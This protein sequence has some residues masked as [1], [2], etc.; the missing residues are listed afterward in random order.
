M[1]ARGGRGGGGGDLEYGAIVVKCIH[2]Y[3]YNDTSTDTQIRR[4]YKRYLLAKSTRARMVG[5][6]SP[7]AL[8]WYESEI[9]PTNIADV[10]L[11]EEGGNE[12]GGNKE[13]GREG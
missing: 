13:G 11:R 7:H 9:L 2:K 12:E 8:M 6:M 3:K 1:P 5:I 10:F 4:H